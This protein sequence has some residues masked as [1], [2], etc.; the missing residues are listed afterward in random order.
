M[1]RSPEGRKLALRIDDHSDAGTVALQKPPTPAESYS[2]SNL[3]IATQSRRGTQVKK[4]LHF[5]GKHK[6][7]IP[8]TIY[9]PTSNASLS[10]ATLESTECCSHAR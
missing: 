7:R 8:Q 3:W 2:P 10:I 5:H 6:S 4:T 9:S 1:H